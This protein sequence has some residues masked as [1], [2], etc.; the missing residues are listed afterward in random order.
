MATP[1]HGN[2]LMPDIERLGHLR[3]AV[4]RDDSRNWFSL[5]ERKA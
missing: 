2:A 3:E 5:T 4:F 1:R